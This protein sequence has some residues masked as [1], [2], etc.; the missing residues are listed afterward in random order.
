MEELEAEHKLTARRGEGKEFDKMILYL[1]A[2]RASFTFLVGDFFLLHE[3]VAGRFEA[4]AR[5]E[6]GGR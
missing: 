1:P 5:E 4:L 3:G 2:S 6:E